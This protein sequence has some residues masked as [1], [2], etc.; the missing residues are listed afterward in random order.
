MGRDGFDKT[1]TKTVLHE[2]P[3]FVDTETEMKNTVHTHRATTT[4][5]HIIHTRL[6]QEVQHENRAVAMVSEQRVE[7]WSAV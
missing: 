5:V 2:T 1:T 7:A 4:F 6:I 3:F